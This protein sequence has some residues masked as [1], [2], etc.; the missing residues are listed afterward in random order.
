MG[1]GFSSLS[2]VVPTHGIDVSALEK[3][4]VDAMNSI[5]SQLGADGGGD[6]G[7]IYKLS[8][9]C[10]NESLSLEKVMSQQEVDELNPFPLARD[11]VRRLIG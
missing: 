5:Q 3:N 7:S 2:E 4:I 1:V 11:I 6:D 8:F 9:S 10:A